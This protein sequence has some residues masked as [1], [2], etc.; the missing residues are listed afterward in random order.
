MKTA[1]CRPYRACSSVWHPAPRA[2]PWA[3]LLCPCGA[4]D[5]PSM[6]SRLPSAWGP[7]MNAETFLEQ[8]ETFAEATPGG[9]SWFALEP[10]PTPAGV[11]EISR[12]SSEAIPPDRDCPARPIPEGWQNRLKLPHAGT[13]SESCVSGIPSGCGTGRARLSG[14]VASLN[15]RLIADI[16]PGWGTRA[17]IAFRWPSHSPFAP[18]RLRVRH[19]SP[20]GSHA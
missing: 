12:W 2:L 9:T 3:D 16:P 7:R 20:E 6:A 19:S 13:R 10:E 4:E 17:N 8:F 1:L 11:T 18:S 14:G 15:H 5:P